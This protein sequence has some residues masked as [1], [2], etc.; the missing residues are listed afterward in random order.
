M[1]K[2]VYIEG[3]RNSKFDLEELGGTLL[4]YR[5]VFFEKYSLL[6]LPFGSDHPYL[7][8]VTII[9]SMSPSYLAPAYHYNNYIDKLLSD[10]TWDDEKYNIPE[11]EWVSGFLRRNAYQIEIQAALLAVKSAL[12]RMVSVFSYYYKGFGPYTTF[13]GVNDKGKSRN[14]MSKVADDKTGDELLKFIS[15]EYIKWIKVAV[16]P[17]DLI[18]HYNDL[19]ISYEFD[20]EALIEMPVHFN[21][22][23]IKTMESK[24]I[25]IPKISYSDLYDYSMNWYKFFNRVIDIL[26]TKSIIITNPRV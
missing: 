6:E 19:G 17:R 11:E 8:L 20:S 16:E 21:L 23:L 7:D 18:S 9:N 5:Q 14:F 3:L 12:D 26:N 2:E 1:Q 13:G 22:S 4:Q 15:E 10:I 24:E 25:T